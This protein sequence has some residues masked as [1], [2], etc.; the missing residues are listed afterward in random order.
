MIAVN[1]LNAVRSY[2]LSG[3]GTWM[4]FACSSG[5]RRR[6]SLRSQYSLLLSTCPTR[7]GPDVDLVLQLDVLAA[8]TRYAAQITLP[9]KFK[10]EFY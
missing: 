9:K 2:S 5:R 4:L 7:A 3:R 8:A 1:S 10:R 6:Y